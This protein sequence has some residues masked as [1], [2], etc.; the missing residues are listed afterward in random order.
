MPLS[1]V[2]RSP[3]TVSELRRLRGKK[4]PRWLQAEPS[5]GSRCSSV[6]ATQSFLGRISL[7]GILRHLRSRISDTPHVP[8]LEGKSIYRDSLN[9]F[10][11]VAVGEYEA[12]V[13][14]PGVGI[15]WRSNGRQATIFERWYLLREAFGIICSLLRPTRAPRVD[16]NWRLRCFPLVPSPLCE[17]R[18]I[19]QVCEKLGVSPVLVRMATPELSGTRGA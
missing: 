16:R 3:L 9:P 10:S 4:I 6:Q 18:E 2:A 13:Y 5:K 17:Q 19:K 8:I 1:P 14:L 15:S 7:R 11:I 12:F